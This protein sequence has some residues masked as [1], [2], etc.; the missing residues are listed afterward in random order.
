M[1]NDMLSHFIPS[2]ITD[3][4]LFLDILLKKRI[5]PL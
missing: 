5:A 4:H 2:F 1:L 3:N